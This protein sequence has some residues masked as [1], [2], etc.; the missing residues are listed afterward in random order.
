MTPVLVT[1]LSLSTPR[2]ER[3][4]P[5]AVGH[6]QSQQHLPG[7]LE[8]GARAA[9]TKIWAR[10]LH[11]AL[12][13][14]FPDRTGL[15]ASD[16]LPPHVSQS[17]QQLH[18]HVCGL[19][20]D[21]VA[22]ILYFIVAHLHMLCDDA[23]QEADRYGLLYGVAGVYE[24]AREVHALCQPQLLLRVREHSRA[25][26]HWLASPSPH[27]CVKCGLTVAVQR[28]LVRVAATLN[29]QDHAA[30]RVDASNGK[31][32]C[33]LCWAVYEEEQREDDEAT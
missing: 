29:S 6:G 1:K 27:D 2:Q 3:G 32:Y 15:A 8:R 25:C 30:G 21:D 22:G 33:G 19:R 5:E 28:D 14:C 26:T 10:E 11:T 24:L 31:Y 7:L 18:R 12:Q 16:S 23:N 9:Q 13:V 20:E 17:L 4:V